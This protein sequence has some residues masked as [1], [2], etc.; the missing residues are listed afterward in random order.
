VKVASGIGFPPL[1][2]I[3]LTSAG[4]VNSMVP[5]ATSAVT[6][7]SGVMR[8]NKNRLKKYTNESIFS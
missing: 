3:T 8:Y 1:P 5:F 2:R 4:E 6:A 7:L